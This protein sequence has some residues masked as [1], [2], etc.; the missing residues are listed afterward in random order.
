MRILV[1]IF[2]VLISLAGLVWALQGVGVI[3]GS[4]MSNNPPWI[5]IGAAT[6]LF[7]LVLVAIGLRYGPRT[8]SA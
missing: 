6:A 8:K 3:L 4:F 5:W 2:G 1:V 7:G